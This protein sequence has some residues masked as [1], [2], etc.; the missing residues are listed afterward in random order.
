MHFKTQIFKV[1]FAAVLLPVILSGAISNAL[2]NSNFQKSAEMVY[3]PL[4]KK[5]QPINP[6]AV[7]AKAFSLNEIC[8]ADSEKIRLESA[9]GENLKFNFTAR[10]LENLAF[11][12]WQKGK[13]AFESLPNA[14]NAPE[15]AAVKN[16]FP[17]VVFGDHFDFKI[18]WKATEKF[19]FQ[20]QPRPPTAIDF[21]EYNSETA[22]KLRQIS[23]R[24]APRAPPVFV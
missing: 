12:F 20:A 13:T 9:I 19:A 8:A 2:F 11:D 1:Y 15:K 21:P 17:P 4:T 22:S 5:L 23:L 3:C 24:I 10:N 18:V 7:A 6:P 14:P 16:S